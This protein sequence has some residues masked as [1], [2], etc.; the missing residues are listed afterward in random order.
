[1]NA[2]SD[3]WRDTLENLDLLQIGRDYG[4]GVAWRVVGVYQVIRCLLDDGK[5]VPGRHMVEALICG[6]LVKMEWK[7]VHWSAM[8]H[9]VVYSWRILR[10]LL[11]LTEMESERWRALHG[12]LALVD[13]LPGIVQLFPARAVDVD[14]VGMKNILDRLY[15][16]LDV[17]E[18]YTVVP[19]TGQPRKRKRKK[20]YGKPKAKEASSLTRTPSTNMFSLLSE[21]G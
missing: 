6:D 12:L 11:T 10:Q 7:F 15:G 8:V 20:R 18:E 9:G 3:T 13:T 5:A 1:V 14:E 4:L 19:V 17:P 16:L 2:L 21:N